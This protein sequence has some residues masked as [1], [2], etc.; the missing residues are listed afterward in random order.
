MYV[1]AGNF[2]SAMKGLNGI[3]LA[4]AVGSYVLLCSV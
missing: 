1:A 3:G 2:V 4:A